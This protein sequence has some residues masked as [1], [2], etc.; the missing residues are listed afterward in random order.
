LCE[1]KDH[2]SE[3]IATDHAE[4]IRLWFNEE[5]ELVAWAALQTPFW[6]IDYAIHPNAEDTLYQE[7]LNW[8]SERASQILN[9]PTGH[10]AWY[11]HIFSNQKDHIRNLEKAG[12][13][14]QSDVAENPWS[15]VFMEWKGFAKEY[16]LPKGYT[17][18]PLNGEDEVDA[19]VELHQ[20]AFGSKNMTIDWRKRT[21]GASGYNPETDLVAIA[22]DGKLAAFCIGWLHNE[23][24]QIEPMG[25]HEEHR[26]L[27]L[28]QAILSET[29]QSL[30]KQGATRIFVETDNYRDAALQLYETVGFQVIQDVLVYRKNF[31]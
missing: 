10:P 30:H 7:I 27:G 2:Y 13:A 26:K 5:G 11:V 22:P 18:R 3:S 21:L 24:G 9:E 14:S 12:F 1:T 8:A 28:G 15:K 16:H 23:M 17:V 19:Y 4:N 20:A 6:T 25:V 29:I 31:E